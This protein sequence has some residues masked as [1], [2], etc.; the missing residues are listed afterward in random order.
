MTLDTFYSSLLPHCMLSD[1]V[2]GTGVYQGHECYHCLGATS[3]MPAAECRES[4]PSSRGIYRTWDYNEGDG[5]TIRDG[6]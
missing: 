3:D 5:T 2:L 6:I 1:V 4:N